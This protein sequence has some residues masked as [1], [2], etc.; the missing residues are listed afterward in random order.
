MRFYELYSE[1]LVTLMDL[2]RFI[3][4]YHESEYGLGWELYSFLGLT[5]EQWETYKLTGKLEKGQRK[6]LETN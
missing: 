4:L 2:P 3:E 5:K 1:G 6:C